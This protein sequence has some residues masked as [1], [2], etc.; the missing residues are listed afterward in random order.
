MHYSKNFAECDENLFG[1]EEMSAGD[2]LTDRML[3]DFDRQMDAPRAEIDAAPANELPV[4]V[5]A[6][7]QPDT[8][9]GSLL[10][11]CALWRQSKERYADYTRRHNL[12]IRQASDRIQLA[13]HRK[14]S[15]DRSRAYRK[16][17]TDATAA[18]RK[19]RQ[20]ARIAAD[21][22]QAEL[23][24]KQDAERKRLARTGKR[25]V[26]DKVKSN[27]FGAGIVFVTDSRKRDVTDARRN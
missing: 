7:E 5:A 22:V 27:A 2:P 19:R 6:Q 12:T 14:K 24:R 18:E 23:K 1:A 26:T 15:A 11:L 13:R 3:G 10:A 16:T 17:H 4:Q 9:M 20:R 21:P 25:D 8:E